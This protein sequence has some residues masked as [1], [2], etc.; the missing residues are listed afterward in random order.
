[1]LGEALAGLLPFMRAPPDQVYACSER[2]RPDQGVTTLHACL[3]RQI[4]GSPFMRALRGLGR[5]RGFDQQ[6][7]ARQLL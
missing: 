2:F 7:S 4:K 5:Q 6:G 1:M 3:G